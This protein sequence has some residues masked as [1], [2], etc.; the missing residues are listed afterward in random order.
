[1]L[2]ANPNDVEALASQGELLLQEGK[3]GRGPCGAGAGLPIGPRRRHGP[4]L[5]VDT[6]WR[7]LRDDFAAHGSYAA[8]I[9]RLLDRP[10]QRSEYLRL[11]AAGWQAEGQIEKAFEAYL[12]LARLKASGAGRRLLAARNWNGSTRT[13]MSGWTAGCRPGIGELLTAADARNGPLD[14][15]IREQFEAALQAASRRRCSGSWPTSAASVGR[16]GAAAAGRR[17]DRRRR[18]AGGRTAAGPVGAVG[19]QRRCGRRRPRN[20]RGCCS[21]A[22]SSNGPRPP[23]ASWP[24]LGRRRLPRRP[25]RPAAAGSRPAAAAAGG[26]GRP[27]APG[28]TARSSSAKAPSRPTSSPTSA[29]CSPRRSSSAAARRAA[30]RWPT[31]SSA[32]RWSSATAGARRC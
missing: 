15:A 9:E 2:A 26:P 19:G 1:M 23:I 7:R 10:E 14:A 21:A 24:T 13:G 5:L 4:R 27:G 3:R 17:A 22:G 20:W 25:D 32:T 29:A 8:E 11:M 18:C 31:T 30:C 6:L 16:P 12:Q 28:P